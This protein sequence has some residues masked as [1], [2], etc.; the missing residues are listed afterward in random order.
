MLAVR[1]IPCLDVKGGRVVKGVKFAGLKDAGDPAE[2]AAR[3]EE[4]GA[5]E[6]VF[7]DVSATTEERKAQVEVVR[8]VR[9]RISIPMTAG[10]GVRATE[11]AKA[12]LDAG[13]DKVSINTAAVDRPEII[14]EIAD[15]FGSQ[16]AVLALDA[17]RSDKTLCG[18]E[19]VTHSG[20]NRTG[21]DALKWAAKA[22]SLGAG[23]ILLTSFDN[24][25]GREG[26]DLLLLKIISEAVRVPIIA[27]GGANGAGHM[28]QAFKAGADA[29][30]AASIFHYAEI[31]IGEIKKY[32]AENE[33]TVR[34]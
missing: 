9:E 25:G 28:L 2:L 12:L 11:D 16:C 30:L 7:L 4:E 32:L 20:T 27:S 17:A 29:A 15:R 6:L 19:V 23:E 33:I 26:Y 24:D 5:D 22:E 3:Y 18:Y 10:G 34:L 31:T 21:I 14:K 8:K 1:I 13:A